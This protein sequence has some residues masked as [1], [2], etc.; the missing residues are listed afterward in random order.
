MRPSLVAPI[1][2]AA[3]VL[4]LAGCAGPSGAAGGPPT[5]G[6]D[7]EFTVV[8]THSILGDLVGNVADDT[9]AIETVMPAGADAHEFEPSAR[10]IEMM[11][12]AD[13]LVV[14]GLGL[15]EQLGEAIEA[16][17]AAGVAVLSLAEEL[18]PIPFSADDEH[19]EDEH[20]EDEHA[21]GSDDPHWFQDPDRVAAA[22]RLIGSALGERSDARTPAEWSAAADEYATSLEDL[23]EQIDATLA[24]VPEDRRKLVTN[25]DAFGYFAERFGFEVVG[26]VIPG[27]TTLA[28]PSAAGLEELAATIEREGVAAIFVETSQPELLADALIGEVDVDVEVVELFSDSLGDE[29]SGGA[30]YVDMMQTNAER[31]AGALAG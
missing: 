25:H 2:A 1:A 13:L 24:G 23:G 8:T 3:F 31:I 12:T 15:E 29:G 7:V 20:A 18:D 6:G 30:T 4:A 26:T 17:E 9:V 19:A 16:A 21:A 11:G 27:G 14:N 22:V 10:Q 5:A 28:E